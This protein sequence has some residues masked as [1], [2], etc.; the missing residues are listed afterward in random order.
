MPPHR[1]ILFSHLLLVV[2]L[3]VAKQHFVVTTP[4]DVDGTMLPMLHSTSRYFQAGYL[5]S[6]IFH[7]TIKNY[8]AQRSLG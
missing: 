1:S 4:L 3:F 5:S 6:S 8:P 7:S 2:V